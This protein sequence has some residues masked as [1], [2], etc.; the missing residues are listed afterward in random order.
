[1][2]GTTDFHHA[3]A[4]ALLPQADPVC[5]AATALHTAVAMLEP[6]PL[7]GVGLQGGEQEE[8]PVFRRR[9]G[10][11]LIDGKLAGRPGLPIEAPRGHMRV[12]CGL[13]GRDQG[14]KLLEGQTGK[15]DR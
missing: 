14:L 11:V 8:P 9:Q 13:E 15:K 1:V 6:S 5:D 7:E 3:I 2:Q 10:A 4:D 12:A